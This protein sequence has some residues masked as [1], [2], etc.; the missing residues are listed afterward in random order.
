MCFRH[1]NVLEMKSNFSSAIVKPK[2][3][4]SSKSLYVS[5]FSTNAARAFYGLES[6][7]RAL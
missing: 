1:F 7:S 6:F 3:N 2:K 5:V 4:V